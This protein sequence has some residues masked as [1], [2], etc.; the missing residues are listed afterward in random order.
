VWV[1]TVYQWNEA[2]PYGGYKL[3]GYGREN[4]REAYESYQQAKTVWI[5]TSAS[6]TS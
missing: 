4:G 3:S 1:N 5:D 2:V 6:A